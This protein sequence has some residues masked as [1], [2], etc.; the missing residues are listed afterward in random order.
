MIHAYRLVQQYANEQP[1]SRMFAARSD[2]LGR[3][4][5]PMPSPADKHIMTCVTSFPIY[6]WSMEALKKASSWTVGSDKDKIMT[7]FER[8]HESRGAIHFFDEVQIVDNSELGPV[9]CVGL[10]R[11]GKDM[12]GMLYVQAN[13][14]WD[15]LSHKY[16]HYNIYFV[17]GSSFTDFYQTILFMWESW[18]ISPVEAEAKPFMKQNFKGVDNKTVKAYRR[19]PVRV[20]TLRKLVSPTTDAGIT[21]QRAEMDAA[22][23]R[24]GDKHVIGVQFDVRGHTRNQW[25]PA[26]GKHRLIWVSGYTKGKDKPRREGTTVH[27]VISRS[28]GMT[29]GG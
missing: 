7:T 15:D 22:L 24:V 4:V 8:I 10:I 11:Y 3:D 27:K 28:E 29:A 14:D 9:P 12:I 25:Y 23:D 20:V 2:G 16:M 21:K 13:W 18:A 5:A 6:Y 17:N 26:E 19:N 1:P